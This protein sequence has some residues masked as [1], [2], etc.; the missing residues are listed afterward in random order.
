MVDVNKIMQLCG[1]D[2]ARLET[3]KGKDIEPTEREDIIRL[4]AEVVTYKLVSEEVLPYVNDGVNLKYTEI[5][6]QLLEVWFSE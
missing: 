1:E 3:I 6:R 4:T 2:I 5:I